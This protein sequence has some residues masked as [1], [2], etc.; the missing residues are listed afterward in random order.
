MTSL[1]GILP[2]ADKASRRLGMSMGVSIDSEQ[3]RLIGAKVG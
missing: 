1:Y 2:V 3:H